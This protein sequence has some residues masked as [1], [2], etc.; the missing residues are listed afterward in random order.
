[1]TFSYSGD[2]SFSEVD[3]LRFYL[4]DTDAENYY[5]TDEDLQYLYDTYF[6]QFGHILGVAAFAAEVIAGKF[7]R[8]IDIS[9]DGVSVSIGQLQQ[10]F[11]ELA[12]S[13]RDQYRALNI[14]ADFSSLTA[15][16][17]LDPTIESLSFGRGFMDN[18]E[19]GPQDMG[20]IGVVYQER[21]W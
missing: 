13:L 17:A 1:M 19:A 3:A 10:R 12:Q 6:E 15:S 7:A 4:G 8:E 16:L 20:R 11:N 2:P 18:P 21:L 14:S 5:L 9:A